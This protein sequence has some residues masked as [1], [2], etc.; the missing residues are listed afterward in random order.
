MTSEE[1]IKIA[2]V[3]ETADGGCQPCV[4]SLHEQ[5]MKFF[6]EMENEIQGLYKKYVQEYWDGSWEREYE[7]LRKIEGVEAPV[8]EPGGP[9]FNY[10]DFLP[11]G[12]KVTLVVG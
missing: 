2:K 9:I 8:I 5:L 12:T 3:L 10:S 4:R 11:N 6:P 1:L 7:P